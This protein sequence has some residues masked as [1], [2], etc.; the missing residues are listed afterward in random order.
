MEDAV[1]SCLRREPR[2]RSGTTV[3]SESRRLSSFYSKS[4]VRR[5][6]TGVATTLVCL[7]LAFLIAT[8]TSTSF[9][10]ESCVGVWTK[11][12][13]MFGDVQKYNYV[14][15]TEKPRGKITCANVLWLPQ[16]HSHIQFNLTTAPQNTYVYYTAE[17]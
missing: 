7:P 12:V 1:L 4:C 13:G 17:K 10:S 9:H 6:T 11:S 2:R 3:L 14:F 5:G 8:R 15:V 16:Y